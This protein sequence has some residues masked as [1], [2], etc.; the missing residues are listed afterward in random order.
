MIVRSTNSHRCLRS[1][2]RSRRISAPSAVQLAAATEREGPPP[3]RCAGGCDGQGRGHQSR[4]S[5]P[6]RLMNTVSRLGSETDRSTRSNPPRSAASD[7]ARDE[8]V[9]ALRRGAPRRRP[10]CGCG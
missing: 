2:T 9:G 10:R 3:I 6:V 4:S 1:T 8:P 7:D 5:L